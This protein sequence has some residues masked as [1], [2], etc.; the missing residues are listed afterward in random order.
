MQETKKDTIKGVAQEAKGEVEQAIGQALRNA[1]FK[2][3]EL[4]NVLEVGMYRQL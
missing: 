2:F 3:E 1:R 4:R